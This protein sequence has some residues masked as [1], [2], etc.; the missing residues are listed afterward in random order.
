MP[1]V[2]KPPER[3]EPD[4]GHFSP[5]MV[6]DDD[7]PPPSWKPS[8]TGTMGSRE[9]ERFLQAAINARR[10]FYGRPRTPTLAEALKAEEEPAGTIVP[11][12]ESQARALEAEE[13]E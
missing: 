3:T 9:Q 2:R 5:T 7:Y 1:A 8:G 10:R 4:R 11:V 12:T 13:E 6:E